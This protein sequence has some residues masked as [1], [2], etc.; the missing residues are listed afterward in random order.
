[1]LPIGAQSSVTGGAT[2]AGGL[3]LS[4]GRLLSIQESGRDHVRAGAGITIDALQELLTPARA[5]VR[6]FSNVHG[7]DRRRDRRRRTPPAPATFKYGTTR[8]W[9][10]A[11]TVVLA[12]GCVLD[13]GARR[14]PRGAGQRASSCAASTATRRFRPGTYA[15]PAVP[16]CSAGYFAAPD[17]DLIDLFIGAEGTLGVIVDATLRVLADAARDRV[18]AGAGAV[19][20]AQ[21]WRWFAISAHRAQATWRA[22]RSAGH[23]RR[24]RRTS[25]SPMSGGAARGWYRSAARHSPCR[26]AP[27][28]RS[29]FS[30]SCAPGHQRPRR[31][32]RVAAAGRRPRARDE[33]L[34]RFCA[35][36]ASTASSTTPRSRCPVRRPPRRADAGLS[37]E[38]RPVA[39]NQPRR[40]GATAGRCPHRQDRGGHDR[41]VRSVRRDAGDLSRRLRPPRPRLRDLG[42]HLGRQRAPERDPAHATRTS[43]PAARRSW[44][45]DARRFGS[46]APRSPSTAS[47]AARSSR[48]CCVSSTATAGLERDA[49]DQARARPGLETRSRGV[50]SNVR[51]G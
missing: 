44:S 4:T 3:V 48:R 20:D 6:T 47:D 21:A 40:R 35:C 24:R 49:R 26:T 46:A 38:P 45:L 43:S 51:L 2:P 23:R 36:F 31:V 30:S 18:R 27:R 39:V 9:V 37:R 8:D 11:L 1:M 19:G 14:R 33:P 7:R 29:S 41:A 12:C 17:M 15:M 34:G 32:R 13:L 10:D 25:G 22:R 16:K 28:S 5:M 50:C 42:P